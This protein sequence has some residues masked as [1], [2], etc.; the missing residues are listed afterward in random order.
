[1]TN[2]LTK[3]AKTT[4][5]PRVPGVPARP[6]IPQ[7]F[8]LPPPP[9]NKYYVWDAARG[10]FAIKIAAPGTVGGS[11]TIDLRNG[12]GF[13]LSYRAGTSLRFGY[14][15]TVT[16]A[17][18]S[19]TTVVAGSEGVVQVPPAP[20][21][22]TLVEVRITPPSSSPQQQTFSLPPGVLAVRFPGAYLSNGYPA[23]APLTIQ[24]SF[25]VPEPAGGSRVVTRQFR[26]RADGVYVVND[27]VAQVGYSVSPLTVQPIV[28]PAVPAVPAIPEIPAYTISE[29]RIGWDA[30]ANSIAEQDG[31]LYVRFQV[32]FALGAIVGLY[33]ASV[34]RNPIIFTDIHHGFYIYSGANGALWAI[35]DANRVLQ[36]GGAATPTTTYEIRR[37]GGQVTYWVDNVRVYVSPVASSGVQRVGTTLYATG[38]M[39][40]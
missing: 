25:D 35:R 9:P 26:K 34:A 10:E 1:M 15:T 11:Y 17:A 36:F 32:P 7:Y 30:G 24:G 19:F 16:G 40:L 2:G 28:I 8:I 23:G 33:D 38:D 12:G 37:V 6:A 5:V 20:Q 29:N 18:S 14:A 21:G 3:E 4:L 31:D 22:Y 39:V 13:S 27:N